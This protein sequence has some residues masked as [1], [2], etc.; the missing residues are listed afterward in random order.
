MK[1]NDL[2]HICN[3][4]FNIYDDFLFELNIFLSQYKAFFGLIWI[5]I[6]IS[7]YVFCFSRIRFIFWRISGV[8]FITLASWYR[9]LCWWNS[10]VTFLYYITLNK[11]HNTTYKQL[12]IFEIPCI[13][14]SSLYLVFLLAFIKHIALN[15]ADTILQLISQSFAQLL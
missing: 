1:I 9:L 4:L 13:W 11:I 15:R 2:I 12:R 10:I 5:E 8:Q 14:S 3:S 7:L 6:L